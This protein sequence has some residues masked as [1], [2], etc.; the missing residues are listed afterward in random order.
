M[1]SD[2][3]VCTIFESFIFTSIPR[4]VSLSEGRCLYYPVYPPDKN[5]EAVIDWLTAHP[6]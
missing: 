3:A 1:I 2:A 4:T 6:I 5:A